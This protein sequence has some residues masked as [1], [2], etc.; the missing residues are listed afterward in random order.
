MSSSAMPAS[1]LELITKLELVGDLLAIY[2]RLLQ[3][4]R[5]IQGISS[6]KQQTKRM[7]HVSPAAAD[8][9]VTS[10]NFYTLLRV[11]FT[12]YLPSV[13]SLNRDSMLALPASMSLT[14]PSKTSLPLLT[15]R[16]LWHIAF[17]S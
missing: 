1:S 9:M 6:A 15:S 11:I 7:L 8:L 4:G 10:F 2:G 5:R 14:G 16:T 17:T 12:C 3:S 13:N